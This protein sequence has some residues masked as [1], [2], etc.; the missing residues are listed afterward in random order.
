MDMN[1][2]KEFMKSVKKVSGPRKHT[3]K[4][5]YGV[6]DAYAYYRTHRPKS[7]TYAVTDKQYRKVI[8]MVNEK[9]VEAFFED[10]FFNFPVGFG[11]MVLVGYENSPKIVNGKLRYK[12][13]PDWDKT[14]KLW[15]E[16]KEAFAERTIV[17]VSPGTVYK[18]SFHRGKSL[19]RNRSYFTFNFNRAIKDKLKEKIRNKEPLLS[20]NPTN[21]ILI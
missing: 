13:S 4:G 9:I 16:D 10:G 18:I 17:K 21:K 3:L 11:S 6:K 5:S 20:F 7:S 15:F 14:Y 8:R 1:E 12:A 2:Y 19:Y